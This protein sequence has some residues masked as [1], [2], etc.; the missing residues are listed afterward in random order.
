MISCSDFLEDYSDFRDGLG[1]GERAMELEAHLDACPGCKSYHDVV[2]RGVREL[3]A[4][5][6]IEPSYDFLPRLQHRIYNL[7]EERAWGTRASASGTPV[8]LA[9]VLVAAIG[10]AAWIPVL[11]GSTATV[12]LPPVAAVSPPR[13]AEMPSLFHR[14]PLLGTRVESTLTSLISD[15]PFP[16]TTTLWGGPGGTSFQ[17]ASTAVRR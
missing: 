11:G 4:V 3:N 16:R 15:D 14:G 5:S 10:A 17:T 6:P 13:T 8:G 1:V 12:E 7:D 2:S 9:L